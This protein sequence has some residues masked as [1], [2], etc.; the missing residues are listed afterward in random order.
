[1][2]RFI[3][4][5]AT[6][7]C[8]ISNAKFYIEPILGYQTGTVDTKYLPNINGGAADKGSFNGIDYGIGLGLVFDK[9]YLGADAQVYTLLNK[10]DTA[11]TTTNY[12]QQAFFLVG[13]YMVQ[14]K[15]RVYLGFG[16]FT[17]KDDSASPTTYT[18]PSAKFG[19]IYEFKNHIAASA[20]YVA[21]MALEKE[22]GGT[23]T[24]MTDSYERWLYTALVWSFRFPFEF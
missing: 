3:F 12:N 6:L 14:P 4:I 19:A 7:V 1:M 13:S 5:L 2:T 23:T 15:A 21:Y 22:A 8:S 18:G 9:F 10:F 16:Q 24:K 17:L 20:D 11:N